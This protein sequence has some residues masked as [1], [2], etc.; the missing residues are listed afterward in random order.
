[1]EE[2][3]LR[4]F[5]LEQRAFWQKAVQG[6]EGLQEI[7]L[8]AGRPILLYAGGKEYFLNSRGTLTES[9][10]EAVCMDRQGL[11]AV[12]KNICQDSFYAFEDELK[13]GFLTAAGGH[14]VGIAGQAVLDERGRI[15]TIKNIAFINIRIARQV[16]DA[17]DRILPHVYHRGELLNTLILAPPGCGKTTLLREL[18]RQVSDGNA[19]GRGQ[20]VGVVDERSELAGSFLGVPQNDLGIRTDVL[21]A[22]PKTEGM[23]LLLRAMSPGVIAIDELGSREEMEAL[24]R[25]AAC[26]CR[27]LATAHGC[28]LTDMERRFGITDGDLKGLF[29]V[30]LRLQKRSGKFLAEP[31]W[32]GWE[33]LPQAAIGQE[34]AHVKAHG[35][36]DDTVWVPGAGNV[37]S[38]PVPR[39][40]EEPSGAAADIGSLGER[41][42]VWQ[43]HT[44]RMLPAYAKAASGTLQKLF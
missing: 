3:I 27:V 44:G 28:T 35:G 42:A 30:V 38:Q 41:G 37:V 43:G 22:C 26:G 19:F 31:V 13:Q 24:Y 21:D 17:A 6:Q 40:G 11:E 9:R 33:K 20:T 18:I 36:G 5:P 25:A 7:R 23:L 1:M 12:L 29:Q 39:Q 14:R 34:E 16:K 8:R 2:N 32:S 10:E 15:R 4:L